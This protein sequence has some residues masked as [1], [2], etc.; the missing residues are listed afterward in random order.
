MRA[1]LEQAGLMTT[2]ACIWLDNIFLS[3]RRSSVD[4]AVQRGE[5]GPKK[6][7]AASD[8]MLKSMV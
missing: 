8:R 2:V 7:T 3:Q 4:H 6:D 1:H 5:R